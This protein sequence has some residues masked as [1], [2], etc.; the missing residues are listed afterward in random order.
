VTA[1][2]CSRQSAAMPRVTGLY[3]FPVKSM[4]G[5]AADKL[6]IGATGATTCS[7]LSPAR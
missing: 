1:L 3:V 2:I 4:G 7:D 5:I 6:Y